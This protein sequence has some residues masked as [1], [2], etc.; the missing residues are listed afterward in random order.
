[1]SEISDIYDQLSQIKRGLLFKWQREAN[2]RIRKFV[3]NIAK[4]SPF[5]DKPDKNRFGVRNSRDGSSLII[6]GT[7]PNAGRMKAFN[8][9]TNKWTH[10]M[11]SFH[12]FG[13]SGWR[14][15]HKVQMVRSTAGTPIQDVPY[16]GTSEKPDQYFGIKKGSV[17][18]AYGK[19]DS[20]LALPVYAQDSYPDW[21]M[22][23]HL[24]EIEAIIIETGKQI[25]A[26]ALLS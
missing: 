25:L 14:T 22:K 6:Y 4:A 17:T 1:M 21:V 20:D 2:K 24:D 15:I 7:A 3:R 10:T 23:N 16:F 13:K 19:T 5:L 9:P 12:I 26:M 11:R 8:A 18:L